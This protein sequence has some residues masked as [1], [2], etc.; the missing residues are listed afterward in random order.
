[1]GCGDGRPKLDSR[2]GKGFYF[3]HSVQT[4]SQAYSASNPV[5]TEESLS[6]AI[7][8][9]EIR[10]L[11]IWMTHAVCLFI[12]FFYENIFRSVFKE[13]T[14]VMQTVRLSVS[15]ARFETV[16]FQNINQESNIFGI[17]ATFSSGRLG[18]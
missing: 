7:V 8:T 17:Y 10:Y 16:T 9:V 2:Q 4:G 14:K 6:L 3:V 5:G 1:M 18:Y 13:L 12:Y 11:E 15:R